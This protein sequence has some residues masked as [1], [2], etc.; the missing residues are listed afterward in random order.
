M[1]RSDQFDLGINSRPTTDR[2]HH[3]THTRTHTA[4]H[5]G[6]QTLADSDDGKS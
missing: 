4:T 6:R 5:S 2:T 1:Y 3:Y